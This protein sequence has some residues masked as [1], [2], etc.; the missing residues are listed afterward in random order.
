M[1]R[2]AGDVA[3]S[4]RCRLCWGSRIA[5]GHPAEPLVL[6]RRRAE[7]RDLRL[8][9]AARASADAGG[10]QVYYVVISVYGWWHWTREEESHGRWRSPRWPCAAPRSMGRHRPAQRAHRSLAGRTTQA[11]WPFLDSLTTWGSLYATWLVARV[12]LENWLYWI[13]HRFGARLFYSQLRGC[14]VI[15]LLSVV[16]LG[17]SAVGFIRWLKTYRRAPVPAS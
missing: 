6:G 10:A 14:I 3:R 2:A 5:A 12:K 13:C 1:E 4:K 15:A 8:P 16:Y 17:V 9:V 11:A 7:L